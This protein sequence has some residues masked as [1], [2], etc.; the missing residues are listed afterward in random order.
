MLHL[1]RADRRR[2]L[3]HR[4]RRG[5]PRRA[6]RPL[7]R[8]DHARRAPRRAPLRARRPLP[9]RGGPARGR[10]P[11]R[12]PLGAARP[13]HPRRTA[14]GRHPAQ[15]R[16]GAGDGRRRGAQ[17]PA[18]QPGVEQRDQVGVV[19]PRG[20]RRARGRVRRGLDAAHVRQL[21]ARLGAVGHRVDELLAAPGRPAPAHGR[22]RRGPAPG[23]RG[24]GRRRLR[25]RAAVHALV[26]RRRGR[27]VV[28]RGRRSGPRAPASTS[29]TCAG[30][31]A[32]TPPASRWSPP[33]TP[34]ASGSG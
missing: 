25:R 19:L 12:R 5:R 32:S 23:D 15:R 17:R 10:D 30:P 9:V 7:G 2:A 3:R 31:W 11:G 4:R 27:R 34:P 28:R 24:A 21:L 20:D 29:A 13:D 22:R 6:A 26:V 18:H 8:R 14:S 16:A 33:P 1:P